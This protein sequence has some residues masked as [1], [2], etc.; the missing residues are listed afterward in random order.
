MQVIH[1]QVINVV[2]EQ[3]IPIRDLAEILS[4]KVQNNELVLYFV[5]D[6]SVAHVSMVDIV[7]KGTGHEH[8]TSD[9]Q[10]DF[11]GSHMLDGGALVWHVWLSV[12]I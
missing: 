12:R 1:K 7:I 10:G 11:M 9:I 6:A 8:Y 3:S 5:R 4:V 2:G